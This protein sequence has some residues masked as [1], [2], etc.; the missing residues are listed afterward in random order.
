MILEDVLKKAAYKVWKELKPLN[1]PK[2]S[3]YEVREEALTSMAIKKMEKY[4]C[5]QIEKIVM[6][7]PKLEKIAGYDFELVIGSKAKGKFVRL[8]IQSKRLIG[9]KIKSNYTNLKLDLKQTDQL[10]DYSKKHSSLG[11]YAFY[12]HLLEN[13]LTLQNHYN[14]CSSFDK[15]SLGITLTSAYSVKKMKSNLFSDYHNNEG[16]RIDPMFYS[17]R[18]FPDLFYYHNGSK[19]NLAIPFHELSYFTIEKAEK[20]N[21]LYNRIQKRNKKLNFF[22]FFSFGFEDFLGE[23]EDLIPVLNSSIE[24]LSQD[25]QNRTE[26][27]NDY[28]NP[29]ALI[30]IDTDEI[31]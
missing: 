15:K 18:H 23:N 29:E 17:L 16:L 31:N 7:P 19:N 4:N 14:S 6:I 9:N 20:I 13:N 11:M 28:F 2:Y 22:F 1:N 26:K 25:F 24:K 12:N 30:I 21:Q 3:I 5:T 8:F 27:P 10:L